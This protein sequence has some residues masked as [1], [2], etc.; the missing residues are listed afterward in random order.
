MS[1]I[2]DKIKELFND[3]IEKNG[4]G[5]ANEDMFTIL[6]NDKYWISLKIK[7][8]PIWNNYYLMLTVPQEYEQMIYI[9]DIH[10]NL[11][12]FFCLVE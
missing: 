5:A 9:Y 2:F 11:F 1:I 8:H 6:N 12:F 10:G 3:L 7:N 4:S